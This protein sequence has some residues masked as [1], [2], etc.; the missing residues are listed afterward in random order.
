MGRFSGHRAR[1]ILAAV[2]LLAA[3]AAA[4]A[5]ASPPPPSVSGTISALRGNV[6]TLTLSDQ[7]VKQLILQAGTVVLARETATVADLKAGEAMGVAA[8]RDG[9]ALIATAINIFSPEMWDGVR[10]GQWLMTDGQTMTNALV[11]D[12]AKAMNGNTL[13]MKYKD[14]TASIT[15]PEGIPVHRLVTVKQGALQAGMSVMVRYNTAS[16][17]TLK[18]ASVFFD[19]PTQG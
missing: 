10:K 4:F 19:R 9:A 15:V 12:Y 11:T 1:F 17:G 13:V 2:I 5:Q 14:T 3:A 16:D 7:S 8:R 6:L 18:A